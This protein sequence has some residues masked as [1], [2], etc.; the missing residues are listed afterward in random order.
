MND[1]EV[2]KFTPSKVSGSRS[3]NR[4]AMKWMRENGKDPSKKVMFEGVGRMEGKSI[5][6]ALIRG[7]SAAD[8]KRLLKEKKSQLKDETCF[9]WAY[10]PADG[11][12]D[13]IADGV[14]RSQDHLDDVLFGLGER[15]FA[16][17]N[18]DN[19]LL[20]KRPPKEDV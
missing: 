9:Y 2:I 20:L 11:H 15:V 17:E 16:K 19:G 12:G 3:E 14:D 13:T 5:H 4:L 6:F 8:V 10:Y 1:I 18:S 7:V